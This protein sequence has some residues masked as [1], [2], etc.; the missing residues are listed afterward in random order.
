MSWQYTVSSPLKTVSGKWL[1]PFLLLSALAAAPLAV[2]AQS[3]AAKNEYHRCAPDGVAIG[4]FDLVSYRDSAGP[5][6]GVAEHSVTYQG[7]EYRFAT[8]ENLEAFLAKPEEY[9]PRYQGWCAT[10]LAMGRLACPDP[11]NFK[12]EDGSLLLFE[13]VGFT[14]GRTV[15]NTDPGGFRARADQN[16]LRFLK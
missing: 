14:N 2:T 16:A 10:T 11:L 4:G 15:W 13:L 1:F 5:L 3:A 7:Y 9:L 6:P 12:I 8:E